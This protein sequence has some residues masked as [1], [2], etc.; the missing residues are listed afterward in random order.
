[1]A[2]VGNAQCFR[3]GR[4]LSAYLGLVPRQHSSGGKTV[5]LGITKRGDRYL[6]TLL[7]HGA[8]SALRQCKGDARSEW[9]R[10]ISAARGPNVAAVAL[11][12]KN[13][14]VLWA[15]LARGDRYRAPSTITAAVLRPGSP[16]T[17]TRARDAK[18]RVVK[19]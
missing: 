13:A 4:E 10:R 12:N 1:V 9:A 15:L 18:L 14:R 17:V 3:N 2:A 16:P 11:A 8:R 7:I 19:D 5:L 6:R